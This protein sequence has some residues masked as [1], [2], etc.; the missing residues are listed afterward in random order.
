[1][2][3]IWQVPDD[4]PELSV[5]EWLDV[6]GSPALSELK[7]LDV[8]GGEPFLRDDLV[9]LLLGIGRLKADR[10]PHLRSIAITTNGFLTQKILDE[11]NAVITPLEQAGISLVFACGMDAVGEVHD[12][13][14]NFTGGWNRL[15]TTIEGLK[16]IREQHPSLVIGIKTTVTRH[17]INELEKICQYAE[18]QGL[19][20][21]VSPYILTAN[22]YANLE[23]EDLL[24]LSSTDRE[25]LR[26]FYASPQFRWSY[27]REEL[28]RF[29]ETG[30]M[31]KPC[32][33]GFNYFFIRSTGEVYSCPIIAA[34]L[35]NVTRTPLEELIRSTAA[36]RFRRSVS[37]FT[38]CATCTEPGLER[39]ALPFEGSHYLRL[40]FTMSHKDFLTLH[41]HLGLEKYFP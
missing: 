20:T 18:E 28:L 27:Y 15:K 7:E 8:T 31:G 14:R 11:V 34:P 1:M 6:L 33:A 25:K 38:E 40:Y 24:A 16:K 5:N 21:I 9:Q 2:C 32:S 29:L 22:R 41:D 10:L 17:N 39:Y 13:I 3:N 37:N 30:R 23:Q 19:F 4:L 12:R 36:A 35:G 26:V